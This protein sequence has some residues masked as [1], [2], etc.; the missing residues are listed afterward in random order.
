MRSM[1][2][3]MTDAS[4]NDSALPR[5]RR[6]ATP[7]KACTGC[8]SMRAR[9]RGDRGGRATQ[10]IA[11]E[12]CAESPGWHRYHT[13]PREAGGRSGR[14]AGS[15]CGGGRCSPLQRLRRSAMGDVI[16]GAGGGGGLLRAV[17]PR[18]VCDAGPSFMAGHPKRMFVESGAAGT[19]H[20][21]RC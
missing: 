8:V 13:P 14:V 10:P 20:S 21:T 1:T 9:V 12:A 15:L 4:L 3:A 6:W 19:T 18:V 7:V 2:D 16:R 11:S 17:R 5:R